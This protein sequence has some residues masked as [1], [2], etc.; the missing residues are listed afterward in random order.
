MSNPGNAARATNAARGV[1]E[2]G[3]VDSWDA[4]SAGY[5]PPGNTAVALAV[6][7][8]LFALSVFVK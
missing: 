3:K 6:F 8:F 1:R 5:P 4:C 7:A 2:T